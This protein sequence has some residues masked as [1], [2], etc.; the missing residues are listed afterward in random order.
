MDIISSKENIKEM[1]RRCYSRIKKVSNPQNKVNL[2]KQQYKEYYKF[3]VIRNP[4]ARVF[5]WYNNVLNDD[6]HRKYYGINHQIALYEFLEKFGGIGMLRPQTHWLKDFK[7]E[8]KLDKIVKFENLIDEIQEVLMCIN[9]SGIV[10]P[11]RIKGKI[12]NYTDYYDEKS[13]QYIKNK[14]S[15]EISIFGYTFDN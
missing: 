10:L 13:I 11:H 14:Y 3:T 8:I 5:S 1:T 15:E 2:T 9:A 6:M 7:G 4:W 12:N